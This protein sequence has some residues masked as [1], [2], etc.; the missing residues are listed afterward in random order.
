MLGTI[1]N[2]RAG[3]LIWALMAALVVGLAGFG[4]GAGSG[5]TSQNVAR[6]GS[7]PVTAQAFAVAMQQEL[8]ALTE[9]TGR[10]LTMAEA[11]QYGVDSMVLGRLVNDTAIDAE[12][13]RLGISTGDTAV[14]AKVM[15]TPAFHGPDGAFDRN[16]YTFV[17]ERT[18]SSKVAG[19]RPV[20]SRTKV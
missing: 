2:R 10:Q 6:V 14:R 9:Q 11:R 3:V 4:I 7:E 17:L 5:I 19:T 8:R 16:T 15:E 12:A 18:S 13:G 1:R 20:R